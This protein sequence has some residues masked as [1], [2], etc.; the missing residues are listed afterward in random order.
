MDQ[1]YYFDRLID[2][3]DEVLDMLQKE[4]LSVVNNEPGLGMHQ[5]Y[6]GKFCG[7]YTAALDLGAIDLNTFELFSEI[8]AGWANFVFER[9]EAA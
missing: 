7:L 8:R 9:Q 1:E 3:M 2:S 4:T 5:W 6:E